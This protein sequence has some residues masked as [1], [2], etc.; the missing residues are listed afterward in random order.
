MSVNFFVRNFTVVD[1]KPVQPVARH[2]YVRLELPS[3]FEIAHFI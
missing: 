1:V 2:N 3:L